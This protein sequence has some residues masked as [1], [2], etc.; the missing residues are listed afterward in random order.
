MARPVTLI[1]NLAENA[2]NSAFPFI[3]VRMEE[4]KRLVKVKTM[5]IMRRD[6]MSIN[7]DIARNLDE[8]MYSSCQV[9][10]PSKS[11]SESA[12]N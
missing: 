2:P 6:R 10:R 4:K 5:G 3:A 11:K 12:A 9:H 1:P 8:K 7:H